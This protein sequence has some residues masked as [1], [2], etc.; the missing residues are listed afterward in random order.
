MA[1]GG[2]L[3]AGRLPVSISCG[4]RDC[5][6][7]SLSCPQEHRLFP[8]AVPLQLSYQG[9]E[10]P[11]GC[12][13]CPRPPGPSCVL[14]GSEWGRIGRAHGNLKP[15]H[16]GSRYPYTSLHQWSLPLCPQACHLYL[17]PVPIQPSTGEGQVASRDVGAHA[18]R[19]TWA[20]VW[21]SCSP[22]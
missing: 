20:W 7:S 5:A 19:M 21:P 15:S 6:T 16:R 22:A 1:A 4:W 8:A 9:L 10:T 12:S 3:H 18:C 17:G 2:P 11:V 14:E 13:G